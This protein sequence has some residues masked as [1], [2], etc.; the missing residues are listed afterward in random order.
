MRTVL[1]DL[2]GTLLPMSLEHFTREY[3]KQLATYFSDLTDGKE[4]VSHVLSATNAMMRNLEKRRN[5]EVFREHLQK[6]ISGDTGIYMDRFSSFYDTAFLKLKDTLQPNSYIADS[7]RTLKEAGYK[8]VIATNP[9]FP[10]KANL[11]RISWAGLNSEDFVYISSLERNC[12]CKPNIEFFTEV[13]S[14][15]DEVPENCLM[16]GNDVQEDLVSKQL[17]MKT[18]LIED[19]IIHRGGDILTDYRGSYADFHHFVTQLPPVGRH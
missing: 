19:H 9:I 7:I 6:I 15:I 14:I 8:L 11:H 13:L 10:L 3:C 2:D 4:F 5:E 18:Y 16:V 17:G 12:Y 1:F